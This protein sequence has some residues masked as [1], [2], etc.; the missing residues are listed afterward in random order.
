LKCFLFTVFVGFFS[1]TSNAIGAEDLVNLGKAVYMTQCARCHGVEGR[2]DGSDANRLPVEPRNLR[3]DEFKFKSTEDGTPASDSDLMWVLNHG[4]SGAGMPSFANLTENT[5]ESLV[6]YIKSISQEWGEYESEPIDP[7]NEKIKPDLKKGGEVFATL[8]CALCHGTQGRANGTSAAG[9]S[10]KP[11]NLTQGWTYR[12]GSS[13]RQIYFRLMSGI[14]GSGMPSYKDTGFPTEDLWHLANY[15]HSLQLKTNWALHV[16][17]AGLSGVL[18]TTPDD[19]AWSHSKRTDIILQGNTYRQRQRVFP[20]VNAVS[21]QA[22]YSETE[23][24]FQFNWNDPTPPE[25]NSIDSILIAF[26]PEKL[27][28][29]RENLHTLYTRNASIMEVMRWSSNKPNEVQMGLANV[30]AATKRYWPADQT[31]NSQAE[32]TDGAWTVVFSRPRL[33]ETSPTLKKDGLP[34]YIGLAAWDGGHNEEFL[35]R[36]AS[37]WVALLSSE[38][39]ADH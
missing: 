33:S 4:M 25:T 15:V 30:H 24:A 28:D 10:V 11:S 23:I 31:F 29:P 32:Y 13:P 3:E 8:Q 22:L 26:K 2:G 19:A 14:A 6:A 18:P 37:Q 35:Y 27:N 1:M 20:T 21:V 16:A 9:L 7:P 17:A 34:S 36:S 39:K 5:K 38:S 12:A